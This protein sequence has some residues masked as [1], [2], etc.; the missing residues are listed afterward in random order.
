MKIGIIIALVLT[1]SAG[2]LFYLRHD[3]GRAA[4]DRAIDESLLD[5]GAKIG[6]E[7]LRRPNTI[8]DEKHNVGSG[9]QNVVATEDSIQK[10]SPQMSNELKVQE[11][12]Q[13]PAKSADYYEEPANSIYSP[14]KYSLPQITAKFTASTS[15][16][17]GLKKFGK[18][19]SLDCVEDSCTM[20]IRH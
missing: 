9:Y 15:E 11:A 3:Q 2:A 6:S 10:Y 19:E 14:G 4:S 5:N 13:V 16:L 1:T 20:K 7:Q 8:H 17:E 18:I 12:E